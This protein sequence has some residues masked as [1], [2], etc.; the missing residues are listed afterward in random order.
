MFDAETADKISVLYGGSV[1]SSFL[2]AVSFEAGMDGVLV[3]RESLFPYEIAKMMN[4]FEERA[5][6]EQEE[7]NKK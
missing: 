5:T 2:P 1:K 4:I 3:G 6:A 7:K